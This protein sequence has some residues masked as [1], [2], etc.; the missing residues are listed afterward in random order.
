MAYFVFSEY[1]RLISAASL[2]SEMRQRRRDRFLADTLAFYSKKLLRNPRLL[3]YWR[4]L[5]A[6][7]YF[8]EGTVDYY[9]RNVLHDDNKPV[10]LIYDPV[11]PFC[12][13][14]PPASAAVPTA[15]KP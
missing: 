7:K 6:S 12:A 10:T 11:G 4:D 9:N 5:G 15:A 14:I 1:D 3:S 2:A 13:T 8:D